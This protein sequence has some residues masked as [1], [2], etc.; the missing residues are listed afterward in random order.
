MENLKSLKCNIIS[1]NLSV[2]CDKYVSK[3]EKNI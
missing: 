3:E 2:I 1:R